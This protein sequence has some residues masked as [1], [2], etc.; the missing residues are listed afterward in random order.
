M[1]TDAIAAV[2]SSLSQAQFSA[3]LETA[4]LKK[5]MDVQSQVAMGLVSLIPPAPPLATQGSV[6]TRVNTFA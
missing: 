3:R 2:S 1:S 4:V 6:G 5:S